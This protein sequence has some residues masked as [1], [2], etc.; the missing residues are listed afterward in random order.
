MIKQVIQK[1]ANSKGVRQFAK[2]AVVGGFVTAV[3]FV[4]LYI[5]IE[6]FLMWYILAATLSFT[7]ALITSFF[8]NKFWT[9]K[10]KDGNIPSQMTKFTIINLIGLGI[11]LT[12]LYILVDFFS[13]WYLPAKV[14]ATVFVLLW[15]F[16]GMRN[17][18]FKK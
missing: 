18:A 10:N 14:V 4:L 7:T 3:D 16:L 2:Y 9:F 5:F 15:N 17:W 8:L 6:F 11:N 13:I 1:T 12:V